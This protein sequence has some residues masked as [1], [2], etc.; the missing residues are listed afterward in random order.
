MFIGRGS[1]GY[2][3]YFGGFFMKESIGNTDVTAA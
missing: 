2:E 1:S 3:N